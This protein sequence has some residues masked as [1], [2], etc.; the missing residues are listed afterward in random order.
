MYGGRFTP[1]G[2]LDTNFSN[3]SSDLITV[4]LKIGAVFGTVGAVSPNKD[5]FTVVT[6]TA[7]S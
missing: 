2:S 5:L 1:R 7:A 4:G 3:S 6:V